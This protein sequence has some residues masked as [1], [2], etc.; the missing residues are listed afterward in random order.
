MCSA[1]PIFVNL[2]Q[3]CVNLYGVHAGVQGTT[4][5]E[6][7]QRLI[8]YVLN[9]LDGDSDMETSIFAKALAMYENQSYHNRDSFG[10]QPAQWF[11]TVSSQPA[12]DRF[13]F[14]WKQNRNFCVTM[15]EEQPR[16]CRFKYGTDKFVEYALE[17]P[18]TAVGYQ[19]RNC[20]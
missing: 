7:F 12:P 8:E 17:G 16:P 1:T 10:L 3:F 4:A 13:V 14:D 6:Q 15:K 19:L 20:N 18:V 11:L 9:F 2:K 5:K